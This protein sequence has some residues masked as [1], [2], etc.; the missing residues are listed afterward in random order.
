MHS[1]IYPRLLR[2]SASAA[3]FAC[4]SMKQTGAAP[5]PDHG[6]LNI[7]CFGAQPDDCEIQ[8][9]GTAMLWAPGAEA[10]RKAG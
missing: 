3:L 8:V 4:V 1:M 7:I 5:E 10:H 2:T 9:G 6:K